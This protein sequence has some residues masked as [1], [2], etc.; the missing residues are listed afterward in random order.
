MKYKR[1]WVKCDK[2]GIHTLTP[3]KDYGYV[4]CPSH[5]IEVLK[6]VKRF[7]GDKA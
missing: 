6:F 1:E 7:V 5:H 4:L 2:C 3:Y